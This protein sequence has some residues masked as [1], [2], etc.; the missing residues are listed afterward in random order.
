MIKSQTLIRNFFMSSPKIVFFGTPDLAAEILEA[1]KGA[2]LSP[3]LVVTNPDRPVG[4]KQ[5]VTS[6][7]VKVWAEKERIPIL[8]PENPNA[9][10][11]ISEL[12]TEAPDLFIVVAYGQILTKELLDIPKHGALNIHYSLL[13]KYR[14]ASPIE[15]AILEDDRDTGVTIMLLDEKMDHGP[16][17][18]QKRI[19]DAVFNKGD[20]PPKASELR[21]ACNAV[22][23]QLLVETIPKWIAGEIEAMEQDHSKATYTKKFTKDDGLIDLSDDPYKNFLKIQ[24]LEIWPGT[25][26]FAEKNEKKV[27]VVIKKATCE[28][29]ELKI[30]RV[31]PEGK[32]ELDYAVFLRS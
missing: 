18:A 11:F 19:Q 24:A 22:A 31:V 32:K 30:L 15:T 12:K 25:Y 16:I 17:V 23:K 28:N 27:R 13:P 26:F 21:A 4:R 6:S 3:T 1:L 7:P 8:Q 29:G 10:A 9:P 5:I 20:W 14:G 2:G